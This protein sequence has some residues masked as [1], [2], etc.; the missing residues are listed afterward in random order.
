MKGAGRGWTEGRTFI[1]IHVL[2]LNILKILCNIFPV[3]NACS[4]FKEFFKLL[5]VTWINKVIII[6]IIIGETQLLETWG[7]FK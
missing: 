3:F 1:I 6:I 5:Y 7:K 4:C 2:I